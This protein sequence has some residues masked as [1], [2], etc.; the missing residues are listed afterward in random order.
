[1]DCPKCGFNNP[2]GAKYC[3]KCAKIFEPAKEIKKPEVQTM[4]KE[5]QP[6]SSP[7]LYDQRVRP[8][9]KNL[10]IVIFVLLGVLIVAGA[11]FAVIYFQKDDS[12][13]VVDDEN[14]NIEDMDLDDD[15]EEDQDEDEVE[16]DDIDSDNDGLTDDEEDNI[17][18]T[19]PNNPDTDGDGYLDGDEVDNGYDPLIAG[20][21]RLEDRI[22]ISNWQ[23]YTNSEYKY[24][25]KYPST[26]TIKSERS[27]IDSVNKILSEVHINNGI[28]KKFTGSQNL[29][30]VVDEN[31]PQGFIYLAPINE[32]IKIDGQDA[33][34]Y[35]YPGGYECYEELEITDCSSFTIPIKY[36]DLWYVFS[37]LGNATTIT[38]NYNQ[39]LS[40]FKFLD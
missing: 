20:S 39:M 25:I 1:M 30:I 31:D 18:F 34:V 27:I 13:D 8:N 40:T 15:V 36:K 7:S 33:I 22:D 35:I 19:D 21:A 24:E 10:K 6:S 23:T 5:H 16:D 11:V 37:G 12:V 38:D 29:Y 28:D 2:G 9:N 3:Q 32:N 26:W 14:I 17:W 4:S